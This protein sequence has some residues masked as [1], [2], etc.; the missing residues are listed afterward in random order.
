M[1]TSTQ[2]QTQPK[3]D[4]YQDVTDRIL[5]ALEAGVLP[6]V[7]PWTLEGNAIPGLPLNAVSGRYYSGI[8]VLLLWLSASAKGYRQRKW[9]TA[10]A[11]HKLGGHVR[12]GEKATKV[13]NYNPVEREKCD[14]EGNVL[15]DEHGNPELE[16]FAYITNH[17][18]FNIEQCENLPETLFETV[19]NELQSNTLNIELREDV[20]LMIDGLEGLELEHVAGNIA[21]YDPMKDKI[22]LPRI[23]QFS[24]EADY[25]S[26]LLHEMTHATGHAKRLNREGIT[27]ANAKFG[28]PKYAFEELIAQM[29]NAFICAHLGLDVIDESAS[30]I[31]SWI[32][33]LKSDKKAIFRATG[34]A[35]EAS[36]YMFNTLY[37][38]TEALKHCAA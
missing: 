37:E 22:V 25:Y 9:I 21:Y 20:Q 10:K 7:R 28:S 38:Q 34:K 11:A 33:A 12:K 16:H 19:K 15:L 6:W 23:T 3:Y 35:R 13:V 14:D 4:I 29:G 8:N 1:N 31:D 32:Q 26:T 5:E 30:Y 24:K 17:V 18:L 2:I 27:A 36:D